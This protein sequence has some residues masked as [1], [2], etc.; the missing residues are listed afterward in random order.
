MRQ[1][2]A[3]RGMKLMLD[4]VPNHTAV[5]APWSEAE[6][7]RYILCD[8][9][10]GAQCVQRG[11]YTIHFGGD[12][13]NKG[14]TDTIQLNYWNE[15]AV[16]A[17]SAALSRVAA[18]A[19]WVRCDMAHDVL[20][21]EVAKTWGTTLRAQGY[22]APTQDFW[23]VALPAARS[24]SPGVSAV[25][26]AYNYGFTSPPET[27]YL[28]E[29]SGFDAAYQKGLLDKLKANNL[30]DLRAYVQATPLHEGVH[31]TENHD[32]PRAAAALGGTAQ[33]R[34]RRSNA[35]PRR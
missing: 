24:A 20:N 23:N 19:D 25:A 34:V 27:R 9:G 2:L 13:Y 14:W 6:P 10:D 33:V 3:Q 17:M 18:A 5:D 16:S 29:H 22:S 30:D 31:F 26:E 21:A 7:K 11:D 8:D 32:E 1:R 4:F 35:E 15:D 12:Y 28:V